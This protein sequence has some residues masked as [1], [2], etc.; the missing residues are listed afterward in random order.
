MMRMALALVT[1]MLLAAGPVFAGA[2]DELQAAKDALQNARE[3]LKEAPK[4]LEGHR[5]KAL[6]SN[7]PRW[8]NE[9]LLSPRTP[10]RS[11]SP[12]QRPGPDR[13]SERRAGSRRKTGQASNSFQPRLWDND[14]D[15]DIPCRCCKRS[16]LL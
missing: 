8:G 13:S 6:E 16:G 1:G 5:K 10:A 12:G 11:L 2:I 7:Q 3:H 4:E 9:P 14:R 15:T